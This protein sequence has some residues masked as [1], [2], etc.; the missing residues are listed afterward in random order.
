M[1]LFVMYYFR[2]KTFKQIIDL[3]PSLNALALD[4][5]ITPNRVAVWKHRDSIPCE[6][7]LDLVNTK[8]AKDAKLPLHTLAELS[9]SK[10][11]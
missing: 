7:W 11:G 10:R 2:M 5:D 4:L 8:V 9:A 3:W 6:F 1:F